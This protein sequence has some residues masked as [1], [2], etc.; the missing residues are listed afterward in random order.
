[1]SGML[2]RHSRANHKNPAL[3]QLRMCRP[4]SPQFWSIFMKDAQRNGLNRIKNQFSDFYFLSY[5]EKFIK[6]WGDDV[7]KMTITRKIKIRKIWNFIFISIQPIPDLSCIC[8]H[9]WNKIKEFSYF[10]KWSNLHER[11][12]IGWMEKKNL[13][14]IFFFY[15]WSFLWHH[16]PNFRWIFHNLKNKK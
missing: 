3:P 5:R 2:S 8:D 10:Q 16:H 7:T 12:R 6:N 4:P 1:M 15:L 13:I 11:S 9:F 14:Y